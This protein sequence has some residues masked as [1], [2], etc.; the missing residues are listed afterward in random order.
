MLLIRAAPN[1]LGWPFFLF[2]L[3]CENTGQGHTAARYGA[4]GLDRNPLRLYLTWR[5]GQ[6]MLKGH[7]SPENGLLGPPFFY[8]HLSCDKYGFLL[9]ENI[10]INRKR[11]VLIFGTFILWTIFFTTTL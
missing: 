5:I 2:C 11:V 1:G 9:C 6:T 4:K 3:P 7:L 10:R 8:P